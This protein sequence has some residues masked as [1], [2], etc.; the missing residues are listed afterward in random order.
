MWRGRGFGGAGSVLRKGRHLVKMIK[1]VLSGST[2][3]VWPQCIG[4]F[5]DGTGK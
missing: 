2:E 1:G 5:L 3:V 4:D